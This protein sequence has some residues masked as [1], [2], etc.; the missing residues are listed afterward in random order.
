[1]ENLNVNI[2]DYVDKEEIE[3][4]IAEGCRSAIR[5]AIRYSDIKTVISNSAYQIIYKIIDEQFNMNLEKMLTDKV[6]EIIGKL[7]SWHLIN[8]GN[9]V[10]KKSRGAEIIDNVFESKKNEIEKK[11][12]EEIVNMKFTKRVKDE[13]TN[14]MLARLAG[15][16]RCPF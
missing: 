10:S 4:I 13:I 7:D 12:S 14:A 8:W 16:D 15:R 11:V 1:M 9:S 2:L 6:T 3:C 5:D